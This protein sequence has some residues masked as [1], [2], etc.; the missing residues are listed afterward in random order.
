MNNC[1]VVAIFELHLFHYYSAMNP[2]SKIKASK[3]NVAPKQLREDRQLEGS[4]CRVSMN[5]PSLDFSEGNFDGGMPKV[6]VQGFLNST[7]H[8]LSHVKVRYNSEKPKQVQALAYA[9]G[10]EI[11]LGPGQEGHLPHEAGHIVQ[12]ME[13]KV[14]A[15]KHVAGQPVNAD[16]ALETAASQ[17][18]AAALAAAKAPRQ[19][20]ANAIAKRNVARVIQREPIRR[21]AGTAQQFI[22]VFNNTPSGMGRTTG[23]AAHRAMLRLG[24]TSFDWSQ[25]RPLPTTTPYFNNRPARYV[26]TTRG[27]WI[28]MVHFLFYA[29]KAYKY[30]V[31]RDNAIRQRQEAETRMRDASR[32]GGGYGRSYYPTSPL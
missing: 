17:L 23:D 16:P 32:N 13:G 21:Q 11:H 18:G 9:Q 26:Y 7:G 8:D 1:G 2:P 22:E 28:D 10:D 15:T 25:M 20:A 12:Q 29:G 19:P 3:V 6:L 30:K 5:P 31:D 24:E 4:D 27:G 14:E